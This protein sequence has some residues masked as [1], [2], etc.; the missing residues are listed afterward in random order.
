[1]SSL[2]QGIHHVALKC[3]DSAEFEKVISFYRDLLGLKVLRSWGQGAKAGIMLSASGEDG[4]DIIEIFASGKEAEGFGGINHFAFTAEEVDACL[5]T[6]R[7]AGYE[8]TDEAHDVTIPSNP[9]LPIRCG[10]CSGP[11]GESIEFFHIY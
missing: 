7:A 11:L 10:F 4:G 9:P 6:V 2:V 5:D 1:M 8:I 3:G